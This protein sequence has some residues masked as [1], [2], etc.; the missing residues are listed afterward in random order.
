MT[1]TPYFYELPEGLLWQAVC[2][3]CG[4]AGPEQPTKTAA[5]LDRDDHGGVGEQ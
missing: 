1:C 2:A 5:R 4:W 3:G